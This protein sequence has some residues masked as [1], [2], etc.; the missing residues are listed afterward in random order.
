MEPSWQDFSQVPQRSIFW[1]VEQSILPYSLTAFQ[2]YASHNFQ[3][4]VLEN[5]ETTHFQRKKPKILKTTSVITLPR[6][7]FGKEVNSQTWSTLQE[8]PGDLWCW[9]L[10]SASWKIQRHL[11]SL[12]NVFE[13]KFEPSWQDLPWIHQSS[14]FL[15]KWTAN[16]IDLFGSF[17]ETCLTY[18]LT[19]YLGR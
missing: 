11:T 16:L 8:L 4:N 2:G 10:S 18:F 13:L 17:P 6:L 12:G 9:S 14:I 15:S 3:L 5:M 7:G 19:R 1:A